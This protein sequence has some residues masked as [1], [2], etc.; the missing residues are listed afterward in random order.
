MKY[1]DFILQTYRSLIKKIGPQTFI[2]HQLEQ[3]FIDIDDSKLNIIRDTLTQN[4][5]SSHTEE[6]LQSAIGK[7]DV[8]NQLNQ[9]LKAFRSTIIPWLN[10]TKPLLGANILEIGCGTGSST[11][12]LAEQGANVV[13]IDIDKNSLEVAKKRCAVY[14]LEVNFIQANATDI[15]KLDTSICHYDFIIFFAALEHMLHDERIISLEKAWNMLDNNS[16]LTVIEAPNRLWFFD[17]HTSVLPF[18]MWLPDE[19]AFQYA[20]FSHRRNY[21]EIYDE[22]S[23]EKKLHFLRR[24]RGVSFHEFEVAFNGI[25]NWKVLNSL[26]Q[27]LMNEPLSMV[28]KQYKFLLKEI[29]P[30]HLHDGF[31]DP[32][33]DLIIQKN[34]K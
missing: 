22:Y 29:S 12:A 33:L 17:S 2:E 10:N 27:Y 3:R 18:N 11:V 16:Y 19:L 30:K 14:G 15:D 23:A 4:Y 32:H 9:R 28:A 20:K 21:H 5:Y 31:F 13:A 24:G 25:D 1:Y 34:I 7:K 6:Y 8:D 26:N